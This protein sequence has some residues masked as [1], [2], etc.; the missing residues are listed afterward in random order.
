MRG[1]EGAIA[2]GVTTN[3]AF[4]A[5]CVDHPAFARGEATTAFL[6]EHGAYLHARD[7]ESEARPRVLASSLFVG[8]ASKRI[9]GRRLVDTLA[10]RQRIVM[11]GENTGTLVARAPDVWEARVGERIHSI[12]VLALEASTV[13]FELDG[14]VDHAVFSRSTEGRLFFALRGRTYSA[15]DANRPRGAAAEARAGDGKVRATMNGR[16][17]TVLCVWA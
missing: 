12:R 17:A 3:Q 6:E 10:F 8:T 16:L 9:P 2:L 13:R 1:L 5:M 11:S 14:L 15:D 4:L 7:D